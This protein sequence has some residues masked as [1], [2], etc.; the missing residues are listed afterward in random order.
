[1]L[2]KLGYTKVAI[3][4]MVASLGLIIS[5]FVLTPYLSS[6]VGSD[7]G[8]SEEADLNKAGGVRRI[9]VLTDR[10]PSV[11]IRSDYSG[12]T[13]SYI[14]LSSEM[15]VG[16][17][18]WFL[19][20]FGKTMQRLIDLKINSTTTD[21]MVIKL[22]NDFLRDA[23]PQE[24]YQLIRLPQE[25][26]GNRN[27]ISAY[28]AYSGLDIESHC[29][30]RYFADRSEL[31][32]PC[33]SNH[34]RVWDGLVYAGISSFGVSG[35]NSAILSS[36]SS[37]IGL[38][39]MRL[40]V[41]S[42]G[43]IVAY[44][45]D[46]SLYGDGV[47]GEGK[48]FTDEQ[49]RE[50]NTKLVDGAGSDL[51]V[52]ILPGYHLIWF[53][54]A[55]RQNQ[56][57]AGFSREINS[58]YFTFVAAY[59][60]AGSQQFYDFVVATLPISNDSRLGRDIDERRVDEIFNKTFDQFR[61]Y[62]SVQK[63]TYEIKSGTGTIKGVDNYYVLAKIQTVTEYTQPNEHI[64]GPTTKVTSNSKAL[65][66]RKGISNGNDSSYELAAAVIGV[67]SNMDDLLAASRNVAM[68][69]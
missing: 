9:L 16:A 13:F 64:K 37:Y 14:K 40:G 3:L 48:R 21:P 66:W 5:L 47:V 33:H 27:E 65:I 17:S 35:A 54:S 11:G 57:G 41:D 59:R 20:P 30:V 7:N 67:G 8:N 45:P 62:E 23:D 61:C 56:D 36:G 2:L 22:R 25:I 49:L 26:V 19:D 6:V 53:S 60:H 29:L 42:E 1:M 39:H 34:Y 44:K 10:L 38:P 18:S 69:N 31:E 52:D 32:D 43:Y 12:T 55:V 58:D 68:M 4:G 28:R 24:Y 15:P 46:N 51:P 50:T 63:C